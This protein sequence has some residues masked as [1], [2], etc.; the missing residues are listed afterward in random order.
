MRD[1]EIEDEDEE[2]T[3]FDTSHF[4]EEREKRY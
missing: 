2:L 3:D 1:I 4:E